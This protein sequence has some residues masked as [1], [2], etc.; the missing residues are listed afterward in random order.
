MLISIA[1]N[2]STQTTSTTPK[3]DFAKTETVTRGDIAQVLTLPTTLGATPRILVTAEAGGKITIDGQVQPG[4]EMKK[5]DLLYTVNDTQYAARYDFVVDELAVLNGSVVAKGLP[6]IK[7]RYQGFAETAVL[8]PESAYRILGSDISIKALIT[9]GPGPFECIPVQPWL[10]DG[11]AAKGT[12]ISCLIPKETVAYDG[13]LGTMAIK[14]AEAK[15]VLLLPC[16]AV[17]G[18]FQSGEVSFVK[19]GQ[20][21]VKEVKLGISDGSFIEITEG[22]NEGGQVL[23]DA[24]KIGQ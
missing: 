23:A 2:N 19:D 24:P 8:P 20:I 17:N 11:S 22:L 3:P 14:S 15:K 10:G 12:S 21:T 7:G 1:V 18:S 5:G 13:L 9:N 16:S 6:V 4:K